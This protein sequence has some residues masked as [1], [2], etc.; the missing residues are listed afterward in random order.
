MS[1]L[2]RLS[3]QA[4]RAMYG[5]ETDQALIMLLTVYDP[6]NNTSI[7]GRMSDS[8]INRLPALTTDSEI[9]YGVTSRSND[10][11]FIPMEITLPSEQETGVGQCGITL[12]YASPDLIAAVRTAIT[13]PTKILLELVLSG[14]PDTVE[15]SF[16]DFYITSV[17]YDAQ[18]ISLSLD[19]INLSREPFPC[20]SFTP[21]YFPGLF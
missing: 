15:A 9:V 3:P 20:Y 1:R 21:G 19:M 14:S 2:T 11:Y 12:N 10:Y 8:F 16:S 4:I 5:S 6:V 18:K 7:V 17:T 13:K